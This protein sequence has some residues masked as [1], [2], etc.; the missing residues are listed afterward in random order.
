ME[1]CVVE[2]LVF[3]SGVVQRVPNVGVA[4]L[5]QPGVIPIPDDGIRI[6]LLGDSRQFLARVAVD[7]QQVAAAFAVIVAERFECREHERHPRWGRVGE[8]LVVE[9]EHGKDDFPH[10][11]CPV[12]LDPEVTAVPMNVHA[13][14][15][16]DDPLNERTHFVGFVPGL[17][18]FTSNP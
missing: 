4:H 13:L 18:S 10:R 11:E 2:R 8:D 6:T 16:D 1:E 14:G 17:P 5:R 3:D 15:D 12:V 9:D 7:D